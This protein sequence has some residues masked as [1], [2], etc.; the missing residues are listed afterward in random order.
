MTII[1][2]FHGK[3]IWEPY[4]DCY[5]QI[6][7]ITWCVKKEQYCSIIA[8]QLRPAKINIIPTNHINFD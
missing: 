4:Y 8:L 2:K 3:T 5:I 7:V 6:S 1:P